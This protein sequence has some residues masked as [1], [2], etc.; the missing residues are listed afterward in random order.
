MRDALTQVRGKE[1]GVEANN[2]HW[3]CVE[4]GRVG[5]REEGGGGKRV[6]KIG[7][8]KENGGK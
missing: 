4:R 1:V 3:I 8:G 2:I 5:E 7:R 6:D